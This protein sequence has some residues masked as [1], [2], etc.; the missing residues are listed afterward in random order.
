M[1]QIELD[2]SA[3]VDI[4]V[5]DGSI[6]ST[7]GLQV[8][9]SHHR[10]QEP[11]N[12][13]Q[14]L[15]QQQQ[16]QQQR[17]KE[18]EGTQRISQS[19]RLQKERATKIAETEALSRENFLL[20]LRMPHEVLDTVLLVEKLAMP[21][22]E[23]HSHSSTSS[24]GSTGNRIRN[25]HSVLGLPSVSLEQK[26]S[27]CFARRKDIFDLYVIIIRSFSIRL[28]CFPCARADSFTMRP[29]LALL[30]KARVLRCISSSEVGPQLV[31]VQGT[32][33][34]TLPGK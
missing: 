7:G 8:H 11:E 12:H 26:Q 15:L 17:E 34:L 2:A 22:F 16:Q 30:T 4:G 5:G 1:G 31:A 27:T 29:G 21:T 25:S 24:I 10:V 20:R 28:C 23:S 19:F 18:K 32:V 9:L 3:D 13:R 33:L 6:Y 14:Q